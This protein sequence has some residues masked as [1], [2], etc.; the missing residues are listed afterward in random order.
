MNPITE[1]RIFVKLQ[2][3]ISMLQKESHMKFS[4]NLVIQVL[5]TVVQALNVLAPFATSD[6]AKGSIAATVALVQAI[7]A[8]I[9]HFSNP[10]G[11]PAAAAYV[12]EKK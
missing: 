4:W 3:I 7:T 1:L 12:P 9:A 5:G 11:T 6:K 10:D 2:P 8:F